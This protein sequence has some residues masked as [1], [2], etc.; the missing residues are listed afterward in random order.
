MLFAVC[1]GYAEFSVE[2]N[3]DINFAKKL[4]TCEIYFAGIHCVQ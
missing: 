1:G 2:V 4:E 3:K